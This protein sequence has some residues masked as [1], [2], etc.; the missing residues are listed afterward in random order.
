MLRSDIDLGEERVVKALVVASI[1]IATV[2]FRA[3]VGGVLRLDGVADLLRR[4]PLRVRPDELP[5]KLEE[6]APRAGVFRSHS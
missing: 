6:S 3:V 1:D 5:D 4:Y 2:G